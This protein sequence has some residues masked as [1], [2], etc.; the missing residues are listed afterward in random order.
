MLYYHRGS[1]TD[2]LTSED[3]KAG[4]KKAFDQLGPKKRVL[5]I[6]PDFT[7]FHSFAGELTQLAYAYYGDKMVDVLPA[8][9]THTGM[10]DAQIDKMFTG[11][12]KELFT[13]LFAMA[14]IS[15]WCAHRLEQITQGRIIRP[16]YVSSIEPR[17]YIPVTNRRR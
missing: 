7:R 12:P 3:L 17:K 1:E 6:P 14:R 2:V 4:L 9:G 15:G 10:T 16:A 13:P 11:I 5:A 8:L